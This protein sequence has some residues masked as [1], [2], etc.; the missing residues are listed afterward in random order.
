MLGISCEQS[1]L[2]E[3]SQVCF[4]DHFWVRAGGEGVHAQARPWLPASRVKLCSLTLG[5][6]K[7]P[8]VQ[9]LVTELGS[10]GRV[11]MC[12]KTGLAAPPCKCLWWREG[13]PRVSLGLSITLKDHRK[14]TNS[15]VPAQTRAALSGAGS[16]AGLGL[17]FYPRSQDAAGEGAAP[18]SSLEMFR[19]T[20]RKSP[21]LRAPPPKDPLVAPAESPQ[22]EGMAPGTPRP[23]SQ[24]SITLKDVALHFTQEEWGLLDHSQKELYLEVMLE[25]VQNLL[26]VEAETTFEVK[27]ISTMPS[28]FVEGCGPQRCMNEHP[29]DFILGEIVDFNIKAKRHFQT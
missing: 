1:Q 17:P 28:F 15:E 6:G 8:V 5:S 26:S 2:L 25:N 18:G 3:G 19:C 12:N 23:P 7:N 24:G 29:C 11:R 4:L 21:H 22:P 20:N 14:G 9:F 27:E 16:V 10:A 13:P